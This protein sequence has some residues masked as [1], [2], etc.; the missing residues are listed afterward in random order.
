MWISAVSYDALRAQMAA[1]EKALPVVEPGEVPTVVFVNEVDG[2]SE[3]DAG[4]GATADLSHEVVL[5]LGTPV[6]LDSP[7]R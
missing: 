7:W 2:E 4:A 6:P 3:D 5:V 1:E